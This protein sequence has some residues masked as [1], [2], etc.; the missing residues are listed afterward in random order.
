MSPAIAPVDAHLGL[1]WDTAL[2]ALDLHAF[3][4]SLGLP[5]EASEFFTVD[6]RAEPGGRFGVLLVL[7]GEGELDGERVRAG[8]AFVLPAACELF[9]VRGDIDVIRCLG[10]TQ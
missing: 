9:E 10:G 7:D 5:A 6:D 3:E 8:D 2:D 4:P 1:G